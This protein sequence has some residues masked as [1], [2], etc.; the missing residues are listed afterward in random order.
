MEEVIEDVVVTKRLHWAGHV[1]RMDDFRL[2]E[3]LQFGWLASSAEICTWNQAA[4][5]GQSE[6]RPEAVWNRGEQLVP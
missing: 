3:R 1:S 2:P 5:E 4:T 6:E